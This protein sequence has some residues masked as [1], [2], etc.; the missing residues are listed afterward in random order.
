MNN[1][2]GGREISIVQERPLVLECDGTCDCVV[3]CP[4]CTGRHRIES[5]NDAASEQR[6]RF[7]REAGSAFN[8]T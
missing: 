4:N 8:I 2:K 7:N 1:T 3:P 5:D 6:L